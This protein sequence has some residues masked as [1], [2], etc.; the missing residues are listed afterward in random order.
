MGPKGP[1]TLHPLVP[2]TGLNELNLIRNKHI[3]DIYKYNSRVIR[4]AILAGLIDSDGYLGSNCYEITLVNK[5]L[6]DDI[7]YLCR[8]LGFACY[9][10]PTNKTCSNSANGPVTGLY[11]KCMISGSGLE[12]I[13]VLLPRK[14]AHERRQIKNALNFGFNIE[15][16]GQGEC[17]NIQLDGKQRFI[18]KNFIVTGQ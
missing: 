5:Q 1:S 16:I 14:K 7:L 11:Y 3:P 18:L 13:P 8:S 9:Q 12:Q 4:L 6:S 17:Y 15:S 2:I 10:H